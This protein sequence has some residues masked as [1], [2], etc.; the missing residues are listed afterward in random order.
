MKTYQLI[1]TLCAFLGLFACSSTPTYNKKE[2]D[3]HRLL[4]SANKQLSSNNFRLAIEQLEHVSSLYP[5]GSFSHQAQLSL[6]YAYYKISDKESATTAAD[7]FI[8]QNPNHKDLDYAHYMKGLINFSDD[9]GFLRKL[10]SLNEAQ[11]DASALRTSF[12]DFSNLLQLFP[13]SEY[14]ADARQR[15]VYLRD[16]L[17]KYEIQTARYYMKRKGYVAA[18]KRA[19]YV[20]E[21]FPKTSSVPDAMLIMISAY[22]MLELHDLARKTTNLF[23][24]NY[25]EIAKKTL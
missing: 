11:R 8:R 9:D 5:F 20:V 25:P 7:R 3:A 10:F 19:Q 18:V 12:N 6:I 13:G 17:A 21:H 4:E 2:Q 16:R 23:K 22:E 14:A 15:M 1:F 24:L